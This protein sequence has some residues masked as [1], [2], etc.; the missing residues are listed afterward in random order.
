MT[1]INRQHSW[2]E[3]CF[4][5]TLTVLASQN[6]FVGSAALLLTLSHTFFLVTAYLF[7]RILTRRINEKLG[8][9]IFALT[10]LLLSAEVLMQY[11]TGLHINWFLMSL[12]MQ[13]NAGSNIGISLPTITVIALVFL[14]MAWY[15]NKFL[16][17]KSY[18]MN[19][20]I[21]FASMIIS[22]TVT[23]AM[24]ALLFFNGSSEVMAVKRSLAFFT[25]P[26]PYQ[27]TKLLEPVL[28]KRHENPFSNKSVAP[29]AGTD[30]TALGTPTENAKNLLLIVMD[31]LRAKDI[32]ENPALAPNIMAWAQNNTLSLHHYSVSNCTHFSFY[33]LMT[34]RLPTGFGKA[35]RNGHIPTFLHTLA[36]NGWQISTSEA[37]ALNWYDIDTMLL[38]STTTRTIAPENDTQHADDFV[39]RNTLERIQLLAKESQPFAHLAYYY[40]SHYPYAVDTTERDATDIG[41]PL[42]SGENYKHYL[43]TIR[44]FDSRFGSLM[45]TLQKDGVLENTIVVVTSDHGE[46]FNE[47]GVVGHGSK[48]TDDQV[49]VPL[50]VVGANTPFTNTVR[51]HTDLGAYLVPQIMG[52][53]TTKTESNLAPVILATCGY[54]HPTA[55][56]ILQDGNRIDFDYD[57]GYLTP[58]KRA[59]N[60]PEQNKQAELASTL[61]GIIRRDAQI[62]D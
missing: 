34:G 62:L 18:R 43:N 56:S 50:L 25:A 3:L 22:A 14:G 61:L 31:S 51:S 54:D 30:F 60:K 23:Q 17:T 21:L 53:K 33:S 48:I 57:D 24:Y 1:A 32:A 13:E 2:F 9:L 35:R 52:F 26:H 58:L 55:F 11:Y 5:I 7:L 36:A 8:R 59:Q 45:D 19:G 29:N 12:L 47:E 6:A 40:G 28:G 46:A 37:A 16:H 4:I 10:V 44:A 27:I 41:L 15:S 42:S 39:N 20:R 49:A 38:P